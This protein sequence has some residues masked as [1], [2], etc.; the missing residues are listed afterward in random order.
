MVLD[1]ENNVSCEW[2]FTFALP[3][4]E[5]AASGDKQLG[6]NPKVFTVKQGVSLKVEGFGDGSSQYA[7]HPIYPVVASDEAGTKPIFDYP[8][9]FVLG[10]YNLVFHDSNLTNFYGEYLKW[11]MHRKPMQ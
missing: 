1:T 4:S 10:V 6:G 11:Q 5:L 8:C 7:T 9:I 2:P 3:A